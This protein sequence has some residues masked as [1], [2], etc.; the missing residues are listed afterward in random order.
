MRTD[1]ASCMND[2]KLSDYEMEYNNIS[3]HK[4]IKCVRSLFW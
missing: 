2:T 4:A 3:D 1:H